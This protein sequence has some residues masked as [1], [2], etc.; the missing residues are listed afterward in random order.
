M[1]DGK[2]LLSIA[3]V[4]GRN[5]VPL[6]VKLGC[7]VGQSIGGGIT[8][9]LLATKLRLTSVVR[10]LCEAGADPH[11]AADQGPSSLSLAL[12]QGD[13]LTYG[14]LVHFFVAGHLGDENP[15]AEF[16]ALRAAV[17]KGSPTFLEGL[18]RTC[19]S[20]KVTE[21]VVAYCAR[22]GTGDVMRV[23][24][25]HG[26]SANAI[27]R[28]QHQIPAVVLASALGNL[29]CLD[30]LLSTPEEVN[31]ELECMGLTCLMH[32]AREGHADV[33]ELL[34]RK[35]AKVDAR[36]AT[37][38][39]TA[40]M[41]AAN[42]GKYHAVRVLLEHGADARICDTLALQTCLHVTHA[43][44]IVELLLRKGANPNAL[45]KELRSPLLQSGLIADFMTLIHLLR[46]GA[47]PLLAHAAHLQRLEVL[48]KREEIPE[49]VVDPA[50]IKPA[51]PGTV[52]DVL[53][54]IPEADREE[55][56]QSFK[57]EQE[58]GQGRRSRLEL[59]KVWLRKKK[60][61]C[62]LF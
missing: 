7:D 34:L 50:T 2:S 4:T 17:A 42:G 15:L 59:A 19:R 6:L 47:D 10:V 11:Q 61:N 57:N 35:G 31:L 27:E 16:E 62:F 5:V 38:G 14:E 8:P 32:S 40:L 13:F 48:K 30:A 22:E 39:W 33:V 51:P 60:K 1:I 54:W 24:L 28:G 53:E 23:L 37:S 25:A 43:P 45:D 26:G 29:G 58:Q 9:L 36:R 18:L 20:V 49:Y 12:S 41:Y 55:M 52:V 56:I 44:A 46:F 3:I 21:R